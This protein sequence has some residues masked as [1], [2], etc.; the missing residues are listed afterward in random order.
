[1]AVLVDF[2]DQD[3]QKAEDGQHAQ[4]GSESSQHDNG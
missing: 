2:E 1:M 3:G 4:D